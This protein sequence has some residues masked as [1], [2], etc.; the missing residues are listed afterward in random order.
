M[1]HVELAKNSIITPNSIQQKI[2]KKIN[3][4]FYTHNFIG[5]NLA[6]NVNK[7]IVKN[8]PSRLSIIDPFCGDGRLI[9][10]FLEYLLENN[11]NLKETKFE[12]ALWDSDESSV[13]KARNNIET[14]FSD[15]N[16]KYSISSYVGDTFH[17]FFKI[18]EK[19]DV[20]LTNPPWVILKPDK[21]I[22]HHI[23]KNVY[24]EYIESLKHYS[25]EINILF[26][27]SKPKKMWSGWGTNL[28]RTGVEVAVRLMAKNGVAGIV[29][30]VSI[31][32]DSNSE[33]L[34]KW[35][36]LENNCVNVNYY[37]AE[38]RL[39]ETVDQ[40]CISLVITNYSEKKDCFFTS[41]NKELKKKSNANIKIN[42]N[43]L[44]QTGSIIPTNLNQEQINIFSYLSKF[45]PLSS[46]EG[47][48]PGKLWIGRELDETGYIN[49]LDSKGDIPFIKGRSIKR[50]NLNINPIGMMNQEV[51]GKK[52]KSIEFY[53]IVW[54]DVSRP[55]QKRRIQATLIPPKFLTGN[56]LGVM[57]LNE[58][59]IENCFV[60][61]GLLS[62]II[63][64]FQVKT[65]LATG[66]ISASAIRKGRIPELSQKSKK[67]LAILTK[68]TLN[69]E[70]KAEIELEIFACK[71]YG[72]SNKQLKIVLDNFPKID[73]KE[74]NK[75][76]SNEIWDSLSIPN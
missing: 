45:N 44:D 75:L 19:Y 3:G 68:R 51:M 15:N 17:H 27:C 65:I 58:N 76:L 23:D 7:Y 49:K 46:L 72:I 67:E 24:G 18:N 6:E 43:F 30:P 35:L 10:W 73:D 28:S 69:N 62:S 1:Y 16:L 33:K 39:F 38:C 57:H 63:F 4:E 53:R 59:D 14:L 2:F 47:K 31:L 12:I 52:I 66:H 41:Y 25:N 54:R 74:R 5:K 36:F 26:P 42:S 32:A 55:T 20:V 21:R 37:P 22:F 13:K 61:L 34:R 56:S 70:K 48:D 50:L 8:I 9:I 29:S 64:E 60:I 40:P 71:L 11:K